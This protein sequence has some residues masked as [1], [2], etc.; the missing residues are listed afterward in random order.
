M[1]IFQEMAVKQSDYIELK[2]KI[3]S[4]DFNDRYSGNVK[5]ELRKI[6]SSLDTNMSNMMFA[7]AIYNEEDVLIIGFREDGYVEII[8]LNKDENG[9][10]T[11]GNRLL[12]DYI[13]HDN[14]SLVPIY[15]LKE[16]S[17]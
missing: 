11:L 15:E 12:C 4:G 9:D 8:T 17:K 3:N 6:K 16:Y 14:L 2:C 10:N 5:E 13:N 1:N 7:K